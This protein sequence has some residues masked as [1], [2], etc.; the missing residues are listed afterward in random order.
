MMVKCWG[1]KLL[2]WQD[3]VLLAY[4]CKW[5]GG[6]KGRRR[7]RFLVGLTILTEQRLAKVRMGQGMF[8]PW[9]VWFWVKGL[10]LFYL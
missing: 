3:W 9:V 1:T 8:G 5:W 10:D 7:V 2:A 6:G 4:G